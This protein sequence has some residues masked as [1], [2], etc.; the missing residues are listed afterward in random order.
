[1]QT[2][3]PLRVSGDLTDSLGELVDGGAMT[4]MAS[5]A[6]RSKIRE[7]MPASAFARRR[8]RSWVMSAPEAKIPLGLLRPSTSQPVM[9]R[10]RGIVFQLVTDGVQFIDHGLVDGVADLGA[11]ETDER[12]GVGGLDSHGGEGHP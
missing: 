7:L 5:V 8:S 3:D 12:V 2:A 9:T 6:M 4:G 1:M 11:V 10:T